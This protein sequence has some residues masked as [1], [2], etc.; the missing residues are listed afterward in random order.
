[1]YQ[2]MIK[3]SGKVVTKGDYLSFAI[4]GFPPDTELDYYISESKKYNRVGEG[5]ITSDSNGGGN[6]STLFE[7][8]PGK[9][10]LTVRNYTYG[11]VRDEFTIAEKAAVAPET[12]TTTTA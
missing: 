2:V 11:T 6:F 10:I 5:K 12:N 9:Y 7:S 3:N 8:S 1:M 4:A